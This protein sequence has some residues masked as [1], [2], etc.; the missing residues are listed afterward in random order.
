MRTTI[1]AR[2][3]ACILA[4][5]AA[6]GAGGCAPPLQ[7]APEDLDGLAHWFWDNGVAADAAAVLDAAS[8]LVAAVEGDPR[9]LPLTGTLSDLTRDQLVV[10]DITD[11]RDP[12]GAQGFYIASRLACSFQA[13]EEITTSTEQAEM[14][15]GTYDAYERV[16]T[17]DEAAYRA[18]ETD[19]LRWQTDAA[20]TPIN[21]QYRSTLR[22]AA[23]FVPAGATDAGPIG[24]VLVVLSWLVEPAEFDDPDSSFT[25]DYQVEVFF[26]D[27]PGRVLH[28]YGIWREM[29][30]GVFTSDDDLF[31]D[32]TLNGLK[33]WDRRT[34]ELCAERAS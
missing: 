2:I 29:K 13:V 15:P 27:A 8:G 20:L 30:V 25:Q 14:R 11:D 32:T 26:E 6:G 31:L 7:P 16:Y 18:R 23:R 3:R 33:D 1:G 10:T 34:E 4:A 17:S 24:P 28:M 21:A 5:A 9:E 12:E 19:V 22:A